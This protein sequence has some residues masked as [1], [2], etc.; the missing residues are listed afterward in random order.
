MPSIRLAFVAVL[1]AFAA[2]LGGC[3]T[4]PTTTV[5]LLPDEDGHVGAVTVASGNGVRRLD[6][7]FGEVTVGQATAPPSEV[8]PLGRAAAESAWGG[9]MK[10]QP[11]KP[12]TFILHF[13][14]DS[15]TLTDDSKVLIPAVLAAVRER[16]PTEITIFGHADAIGPETRNLKLSAERARVVAE[17]LRKADPTLDH[18]ELQ[19]F[20]DRVPLYK[21]EANV[22]EPR[23]RR[24][25]VQI[26]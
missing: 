19:S 13:L 6:S 8:T 3:A 4:K 26:L 11:H 21:S 16:K 9:L 23:N 1:V 14:L 15:T 2:C 5:V 7:A 12:V 20:G 24:V 25:E 10:A 17:L 22:P 18:I